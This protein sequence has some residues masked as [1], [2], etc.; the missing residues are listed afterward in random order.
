MNPQR[1]NES[2]K[3][4]VTRLMEEAVAERGSDYQYDTLSG[5]DYVRD[6]EPSCIVGCVLAAAGVPLDK[7]HQYEGTSASMVVDAVAPHEWADPDIRS[8]LE[9][10]QE[11]QDSGRPWG[12]AL[13]DFKTRVI[14]FE[15]DQ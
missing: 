6:G 13:E 10:A 7:L 1:E 15:E 8:A 9:L 4:Y 3:E 14:G 5:C 2:T 11:S 12:E